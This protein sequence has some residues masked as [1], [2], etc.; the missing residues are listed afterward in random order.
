MNSSIQ[1]SLDN[2]VQDT[3]RASLAKVAEILIELAK[4]NHTQVETKQQ[5]NKTASTLP[6]NEDEA[7][8]GADS[9]VES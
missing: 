7:V 5:K 9:P 2:R 4:R 6:V 1:L 8:R 3:R